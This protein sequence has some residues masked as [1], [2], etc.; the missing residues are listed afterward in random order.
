MAGAAW[1]PPAGAARPALEESG[2]STTATR[3]SGL[4]T[5]KKLYR[6]GSAQEAAYTYDTEGRLVS[7]Q[8]PNN[9]LT[10][11]YTFD[12]MGRP[13]KLT[14]NQAT[15]VDWA[16]DVVYNAAG[17]ITQMK[18][19]RNTSG[20]LY[21]T[22]TRQYNVLGQ[23]TQLTVPSVVNRTYTFSRH[24]QR[25]PHHAD[26]GRHLGRND[27]L[28]IRQPEAAELGRHH[29]PAVGPEFLYL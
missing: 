19:T 24:P 13:N 11:T 10:F 27:R 3:P 20:S 7:T 15:P 2:R 25:R 9:G 12:S 16:K 26:D 28:S 21:Y 22:E 18:Y 4:A 14:D 23:L 29:R 1:P 8:Y 17:Q 5:K 6:G